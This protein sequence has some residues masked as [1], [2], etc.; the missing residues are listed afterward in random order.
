MLGRTYGQN[1]SVAR[2]LELV[3]ER[4][5]FLIIRDAL[6]G[7]T[8]FDAFLTRLGVARNVLTDRLNRLVDNGIL[9]RVQYQDRPARHEYRLTGKGRD[10]SPVIITMME[11]G[12]RYLAG[13]AGPPLRIEHDGC[14]GHAVSQLFCEEC[15]R[16]LTVDEIAP[17]PALADALARGDM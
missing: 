15:E 4:W 13:E 12:D 1:C 14:G 2:T 16:P 6:M 7:V 9:D 8:R 5:T 17:R 11:W 3:G 10:L